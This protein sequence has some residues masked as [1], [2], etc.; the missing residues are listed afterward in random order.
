MVHHTK[1]KIV[2]FIYFYWVFR[3]YELHGVQRRTWIFRNQP[4]E[5]HYSTDMNTSQLQ[6]IISCDHVLRERVLGVFAADQLPRTIPIF[7]CGF[8]A[9]TDNSNRPGQHWVAFF[10][11]DDNVVEFFDSYGQNPGLYN[12]QFTSWIDR[13]AKTVLVNELRLQSDYSNVCGLY[14]V[15]FL[16]QRLLREGMDQILDRFSISDTE[17]NDN[18]ILKLFSRVYPNCVQNGSAYNQKCLPFAFR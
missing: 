8:I 3:T 9:N 2:S 6:C 14:A 12:G 5:R 13:H 7:P 4:I 18:Y 10:I 17:A 11:R 16:R 15:Y 1:G